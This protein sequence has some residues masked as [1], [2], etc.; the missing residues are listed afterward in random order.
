MATSPAATTCPMTVAGSQSSTS[1]LCENTQATRKACPCGAAQG[2]RRRRRRVQG[3]D[4]VFVKGVHKPRA[5][6]TYKLVTFVKVQLSTEV[7][8]KLEITLEPLYRYTYFTIVTR[9]HG[10]VARSLEGVHDAVENEAV[11]RKTSQSVV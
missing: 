1:S 9:T 6:D 10:A 5:K 11:M 4:P 3:Y 8:H 7:L 2:V